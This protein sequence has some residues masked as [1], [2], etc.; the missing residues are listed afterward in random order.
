MEKLQIKPSKYAWGQT[1]LPYLGFIVGRD[2]IK[3]DPN[4]VEA[5]TTWPTPTTVKEVQQFLGLTNFF[6]KFI[7]G[8]AK[9]VAPIIELTKKT[10]EWNWSAECKQAFEKLK[11]ALVG[12]PVLAIPDPTAPFD[13]ITDSCGYGIGAVLM[14]HDKPVAF[15][16][17][18]M[19]D[20]ERNY[21]P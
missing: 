20:A 1:E 16:S 11:L 19:T 15:Y 10:V 3:P 17:R 18:K 5:V 12:A 7:L 4:K 6:R 9:L 13:L 8:H 21:A 14:Q 2:G